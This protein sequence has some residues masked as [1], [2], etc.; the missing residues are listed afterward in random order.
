MFCTY[1]Y[2][3]TSS[4]RH[5]Y[6]AFG[7]P[8]SFRC[9][10][11]VHWDTDNC[12]YPQ[13][14]SKLYDI[15]WN[16]YNLHAARVKIYFSSELFDYLFADEDTRNCSTWFSINALHLNFIFIKNWLRSYKIKGKIT[17]DEQH[18]IICF[19]T[20]LVRFNDMH[21]LKRNGFTILYIL[22]FLV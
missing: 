5:G 22:Y 7:F 10:I 8:K 6:V 19:I 16:Y 15:I 4:G 9:K 2:I 11:T 13:R 12:C 21:V 3:N 14:P 1:I 17:L 18:L 20:D